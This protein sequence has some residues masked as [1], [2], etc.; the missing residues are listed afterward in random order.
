MPFSIRPYRRF[1]VRCVVTSILLLL[2]LT[3]CVT[4]ERGQN[5]TPDQVAWIQKGV[6][7]RGEVLERFGSPLGE[8]PDG[9]M[10]E[11]STSPTT[12]KEDGTQTTI[13]TSKIGPAKYTKAIYLHTRTDGGL[14]MENKVTQ[15][16][17]TIRYDERGI[18]QD[19][20]LER[21]R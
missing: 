17:L 4:Y 8:A 11:T 9:V 1:P 16:R 7:T 12:T 5:I 3:S 14:F 20:E 2:T 15:E 10:V 21:L 18:V 19:F 13:M 6:T